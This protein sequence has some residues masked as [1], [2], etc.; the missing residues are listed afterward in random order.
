MGLNEQKKAADV[1]F[2]TNLPPL[3]PHFLSVLFGPFDKSKTWTFPCHETFPPPDKRTELDTSSNLYSASSV[4]QQEYGSKLFDTPERQFHT[5]PRY[6]M[7][8][9]QFCLNFRGTKN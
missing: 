7:T 6:Q 8:F 2:Q 1:S 4:H 3:T 5:A 9:G